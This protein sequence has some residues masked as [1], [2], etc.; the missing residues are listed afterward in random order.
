MPTIPKFTRLINFVKF[1]FSYIIYPSVTA[2]LPFMIRERALKPLLKAATLLAV[3][4]FATACASP[5]TDPTPQ[6]SPPTITLQTLSSKLDKVAPNGEDLPIWNDGGAVAGVPYAAVFVTDASQAFMTILKA[7]LRQGGIVQTSMPSMRFAPNPGTETFNTACSTSFGTDNKPAY[8]PQD[9]RIYLGEAW[10][11]ADIA[12]GGRGRALGNLAI[13]LADAT[14]ALFDSVGI[15]LTDT[16]AD[17]ISRCFAGTWWGTELY[18]GK[19]NADEAAADAETREFLQALAGTPP[20]GAKTYSQG[21]TDSV[22]Y[23]IDNPTLGK[24]LKKYG[25]P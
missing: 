13:A 14:V 23:G 3:A 9:D 17:L 19:I 16:Q 4:A 2:P 11:R 5:A 15:S 1:V 18:Y 6:P 22:Q 8:C 7:Q 20:V 24:C 12:K 10:L 21:D 25:Q